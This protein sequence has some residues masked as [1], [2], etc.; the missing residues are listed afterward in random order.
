[1]GERFQAQIKHCTLIFSTLPALSTLSTFFVIFDKAIHLITIY[2]LLTWIN[3][4]MNP[5]LHSG[6]VLGLRVCQAFAAFAL[7]LDNTS[8]N[9][10]SLHDSCFTGGHIF[11]FF[12][13]NSKKSISFFVQFHA[14]TLSVRVPRLQLLVV[15][16]IVC[17]IPQISCHRSLLGFLRMADFTF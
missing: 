1:M 17:H 14:I 6:W 9:T 10:L 16:K 13:P 8:T 3:E 4:W 15:M 5:T 7:W 2:S 11:F 12:L